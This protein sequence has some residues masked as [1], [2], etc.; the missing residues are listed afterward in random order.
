[1]I[2]MVVKKKKNPK[3]KPMNLGF[4]K[5]VKARWRRPRGVDNKK[6]IRKRSA[7]PVPRIGYKNAADVR[8]LHPS[9]KKEVLVHNLAELLAAKDV[10]VRIAGSVGGKKRAVLEAKA[11]ELK[12]KVVNATVKAEK[13]AKAKPKAEKPATKPKT[14]A[15]KTAPAPAPKQ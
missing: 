2:K 13:E 1:V 10:V 4:M 6:R 12:L 15:K 9:G 14:E 5:S 3:F 11:A 7:G 8:F